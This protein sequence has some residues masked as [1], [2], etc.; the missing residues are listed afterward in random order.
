MSANEDL[1]MEHGLL[2]R[3]LLILDD[4]TKKINLDITINTQLIKITLMIIR[5][6]FQD[7][8]EKTEEKYIFPRLINTVHN[9][10][11]LELINQHKVARCLVDSIILD[12]DD[13]VDIRLISQKLRELIDMYK[14]H[15][16]RENSV[17]FNAFR[18]S[19]SSQEYDQLE[20]IM[21][22]EEEELLGENAYERVLNLVI[23]IEK[24]LN[25][26]DLK[27]KTPKCIDLIN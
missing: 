16:A 8:H 19:I 17:I 7:H 14:I 24:K 6:F 13:N 20:K 26:H 5:K 27:T 12:L 11:V 23:M 18:K 2:S 25:I 10:D 4:L 1:M 9:D 15:E 22:D 21:D 3:L